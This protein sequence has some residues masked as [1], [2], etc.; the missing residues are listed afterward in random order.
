MAH[1]CYAFDCG[2]SCGFNV[3]THVGDKPGTGT[4]PGA[5]VLVIDETSIYWKQLGEIRSEI[6][7]EQR[8]HVHLDG[9][10]RFRKL[11][12][13]PLLFAYQLKLDPRPSPYTTEE[14]LH[15]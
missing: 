11:R 6:D 1:E 7:S 15:T 14:P 10:G 2:F 5:R 9:M 8:F 12:T 4:P 13:L 3:E